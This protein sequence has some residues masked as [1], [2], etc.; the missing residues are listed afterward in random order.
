MVGIEV[1]CKKCDDLNIVFRVLCDDDFEKGYRI[2]RDPTAL[3]CKNSP[4]YDIVIRNQQNKITSKNIFFFFNSLIT[5]YS[6][7]KKF[8]NFFRIHSIIII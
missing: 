4:N 1:K 7:P 6:I 5:Y 3:L 2:L 8:S